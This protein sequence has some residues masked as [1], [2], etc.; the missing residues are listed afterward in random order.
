[1][2]RLTS[3]LLEQETKNQKLNVLFIGDSQ[4]AGDDS[5]AH[6]L[7]KRGIVTGDISAKAGLSMKSIYN[8][9][10]S[11]FIPT[12][13]DVISIQGGNNDASAKN[14]DRDS[15]ENII[16]IANENNIPVIIITA[17]SMQFI[18]KQTYPG[19]YPS[20]D[21]IPA[22]QKSLESADVRIVDAYS[23]LNSKS[24]YISDGLHLNTNAHNLLMKAWAKVASDINPNAIDID[25]LSTNINM[26]GY[27][28]YGDIG[29]DVKTMQEDLI[30][31]NYSVG[32]ELNDGIFGPHTQDG[33]KAFQEVNNISVDGVVTKQM[34][35]LL[36]NKSAIPCPE[37]IQQELEKKIISSLPAT[38]STNSA[39]YSDSIEDQ[40]FALIADFEKFRAT[41]YTDTDGYQRIGYGSSTITFKDNTVIKLGRKKSAYV[42]SQEDATRDLKRRIKDEFLPGVT[43]TIREWG[44]DPDKFNDATLAVLTSVKYNY[45]SLKRSLKPAI[46]SGDAT[47][48]ALAI[49]SLSA[50][51]Q[52]RMSE[53]DYILNSLNQSDKQPVNKNLANNKE[54]PS[55][56]TKAINAVKNTLGIGAGVDAVIPNEPEID[57]LENFNI[58]NAKPPIAPK[59]SGSGFGVRVHPIRGNTGMHWG[60]DYG[61]KLGQ[62][63]VI[64]K[65]GVC[66]LSQFSD[67]AGN[68]VMIKHDDGAITT[69]MH[70]S[71]LVAKKG[72][73]LQTGDIIGLVGSTGWST[74]P[75]LHFEYK[76]PGSSVRV[77]GSGVA[78]EYFGFG[79]KSDLVV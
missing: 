73:K 31:L 78:S 39:T 26:A 59:G 70:F 32:P 48:V 63:V 58:P 6:Q 47:Q 8:R 29:T 76:P 56:F 74:G 71:K 9:F 7:I 72:D 77:D 36:K 55:L 45:G 17:P 33:V 66:I 49:Q 44:Q 18:N 65:P 52:R 12:K 61:G 35:D 10:K 2:I 22:W 25:R 41:S 79:D 60:I 34:L 54:E 40:A 19:K 62:P 16:S 68:Y 20:Q 53:G 57:N 42:I 13:Y 67:S 1:M 69:Y 64:N 4:T 24:N 21:T 28:K 15:F 3:L 37:R 46:K 38:S 51:K 75:H 30:E 23:L 5:Y 14:F 43:D 11:E 27:L 50:N